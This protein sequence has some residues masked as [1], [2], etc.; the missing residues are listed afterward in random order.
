MEL[1]VARGKCTPQF[2]EPGVSDIIN[3]IPWLCKDAEGCSC[4]GLDP[5]SCYFHPWGDRGLL[6][7]GLE[8]EEDLLLLLDGAQ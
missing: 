8:E 3:L 4:D 1:G 2:G 5:L 7:C 6:T